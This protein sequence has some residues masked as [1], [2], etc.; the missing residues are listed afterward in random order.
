M[1]PLDVDQSLLESL[2]HEPTPAR[3]LARIR[4]ELGGASFEHFVQY[5]FDRAGYIVENTTLQ[6]GPG[7]DLK[8][9]VGVIRVRPAAC[10]S[11]KH[12]Q[13]AIRRVPIGEVRE[14]N[15]ATT[16]AG[17]PI[18][19]LVTNTDFAQPALAAAEHYPRLT[20]VNGDHLFRYIAY[21]RG[22]R[23]PRSQAPYIPPD[24]LFKADAISWRTPQ[25]TK[26]LAIANNKGGVGKTTTALYLSKRFAEH[27]QR[28]LLVDLDS[29]M[30]ATQT[31]PNPHEATSLSLVDYFE[32]R[33]S[34]FQLVR[35][36]RIPR[37]FVIPCSPELR[38][39]LGNT[40]GGPQMELQFAGDLHASEVR[41][42]AFMH[43][44]EFDWIIIDTPPDMTF[45]TRAALTAAH[46]V[47]APTEPS[48]YSESGLEQLFATV[49][50]VEGLTGRTLRILGCVLTKWQNNRP[51]RTM[52][53]QLT[54]KLKE[55]SERLG[56][57]DEGIRMLSPYIPL[58][59]TVM[60]DEANRFHIPGLRSVGAP[61]KYTELAEE[62]LSRVH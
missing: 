53:D 28:V 59:P 62:V 31:L 30:N 4:E 18:G 38:L 19:Y 40:L 6:F 39:A 5:G 32:G 41:P 55:L 37:L 43:D 47:L 8:L 60:T 54:G 16:D 9:H 26:V 44:G 46:Y 58:D 57:D 45:R 34:L 10:V 61:A 20:L 1:P 12:H 29:Q 11:I 56:L 50:A 3:M 36:T 23:L 22:S 17:S 7:L 25:T 42:P 49:Q 2:F 33:A 35:P 21:V 13:L 52:V 24:W 14:F 51:Q 48:P 27:G 15:T